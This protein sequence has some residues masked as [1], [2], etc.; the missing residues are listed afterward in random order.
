MPGG[1]R[2]GPLG[3]GPM[4][5]RAAGFCAGYNV[6]GYM[7]PYGGRGMGYG[8]MMGGRG[9]GF[10]RGRGFGRFVAPYVQPQV[11][12]VAPQPGF[13][14]MAYDESA[15]LEALRAQAQSIEATLSGIQQRIEALETQKAEK[16]ERTK[17]K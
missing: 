6:P 17:D 16:T 12:P 9:G 8:R 1:D 10:G 4:T 3:M 7:N 5:G 11:Y 14:A 2:T 13:G 15:E